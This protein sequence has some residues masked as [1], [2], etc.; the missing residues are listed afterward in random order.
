MLLNARRMIGRGADDLILVAIE[1]I[2]ERKTEVRQG[3]ASST[4]SP[5]SCETP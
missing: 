5:T 4:C 3:G 1:D 2:T